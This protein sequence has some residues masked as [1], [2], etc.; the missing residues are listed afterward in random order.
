MFV[1]VRRE[2]RARFE[3]LG[4]VQLCLQGFKPKKRAFSAVARKERERRA[5][6]GETDRGNVKPPPS[7]PSM[8]N[9]FTDFV[10]CILIK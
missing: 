6:S 1:A 4:G 2:S 7:H 5:F 3:R 8:T 9:Y 10:N